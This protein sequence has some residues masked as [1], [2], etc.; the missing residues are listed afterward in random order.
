VRL[1]SWNLRCF[2]GLWRQTWRRLTLQ[3]LDG[4]GTVLFTGAT[5]CIFVAL[6]WI[7]VKDGWFSGRIVLLLFA[8]ALTGIGWIFIQYRRGEN[9]TLPGTI[10]KMR[11]IAAGAIYSFLMGASFYFLLYYVAVWF[12]PSRGGRL[13]VRPILATND[14]WAVYRDVARGPEL[15]ICELC[16]TIYDHFDHCGVGKLRSSLDLDTA[17]FKS[18]VGL[19]DRAFRTRTEA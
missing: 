6:Q 7:G 18:C 8:F 19:E 9:A 17:H 13:V 4:I 12:K 5:S 2:S 11:S 3:K 15:A 16:F 1:S 10:V 14:P